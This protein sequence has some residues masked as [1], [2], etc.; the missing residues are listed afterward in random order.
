MASLNLIVAISSLRAVLKKFIKNRHS[1]GLGG[2]TL[3]KATTN[4]K[5][6]KK[7]RRKRQKTKTETE[8]L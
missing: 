6:N 8:K 1:C 5:Q 7:S 2:G 3:P 4:S